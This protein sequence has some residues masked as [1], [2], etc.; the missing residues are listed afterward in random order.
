MCVYIYKT[1]MCLF[2]YVFI[3]YAKC[4]TI[5]LFVTIEL[6]IKIFSSI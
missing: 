5:A 3:P 2:I 6:V 4:I 1:S